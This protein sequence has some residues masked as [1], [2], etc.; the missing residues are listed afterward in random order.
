MCV[1]VCIQLH[2]F[3]SQCHSNIRFLQQIASS[4]QKVSNSVSWQGMVFHFT[5]VFSNF[6]KMTFRD[7][8]TIHT[9]YT[10]TGLLS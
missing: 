5:Q 8:L 2:R 4:G 9:I 10:C 7:S 3:N 1:C 6:R